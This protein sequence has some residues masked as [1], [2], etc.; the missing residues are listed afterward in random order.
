MHISSGFI[1]TSHEIDHDCTFFSIKS[2][3]FPRKDNFLQIL[4]DFP[5]NK[6]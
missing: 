3:K 1:D 2:G 6:G 4:Y 5:Q